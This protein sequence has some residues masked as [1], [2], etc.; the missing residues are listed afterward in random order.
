MTEQIV[1]ILVSLNTALRQLKFYPPEHPICVSAI[2][3]AFQKAETALENEDWITIGLSGETM[4]CQ[5]HPLVELG[6]RADT[7]CAALLS[8]D[9]SWITFRH[10]LVRDELTGWLLHLRDTSQRAGTKT[11]EA[12]VGIWIRMG[13]RETAGKTDDS[14]RVPTKDIVGAFSD[15]LRI[16]DNPEVKGIRELMGGVAREVDSDELPLGIV[17]GALDSNQYMVQRGL[18]VSLISMAVGKGMGVDST[19]LCDIGL[20]GLFCDIALASVNDRLLGSKHGDS[21]DSEPWNDHPVESARILMRSQ[22]PS[23]AVVAASEHHWGLKYASPARHPFSSIVGI[24]DDVVGRI[25]GG[26]GQPGHRL[27]T[28]LI[29]LAREGDHYPHELVWHLFQMSGLF[30]EGSPVRLSNKKRATIEL[31]NPRDPLRPRVVLEEKE[32]PEPSCDLSKL[33]RGPTIAGLV[34][35]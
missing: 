29:G 17:E 1:D 28:A 30:A 4:I 26:Y 14:D 24:A 7:L 2:D 18:L 25:L 11:P 8:L 21:I 32:T 35:D 12:W 15:W 3:K 9:V 22:A 10:G 13:G 6:K 33:A 27:D 23:I 31:M 20:A 19:I 16:G 34:L 5:G